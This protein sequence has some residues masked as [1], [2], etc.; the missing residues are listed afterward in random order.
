MTISSPKQLNGMA[1]ATTVTSSSAPTKNGCERRWKSKNGERLR[2]PQGYRLRA[3]G[4]CARRNA[5]NGQLEM[6]LV[7]AQRGE[8]KANVGPSI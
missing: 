1:T 8:G 3:A 5:V 6:L 2:D 4:V 7:S